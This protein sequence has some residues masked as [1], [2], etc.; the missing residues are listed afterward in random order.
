MKVTDM[1]YFLFI[2]LLVAVV[3]TILAGLPECK[4]SDDDESG[5]GERQ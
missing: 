2:V 1:K 4:R 3:I 5:K